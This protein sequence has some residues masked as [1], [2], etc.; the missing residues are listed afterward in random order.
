MGQTEEKL[1]GLLH[2]LGAEYDRMFPGDPDELLDQLKV[3]QAAGSRTPRAPQSR[4]WIASAALFVL[5]AV[6]GTLVEQ[7]QAYRAAERYKAPVPPQFWQDVQ[8]LYLPTTYT[9]I[10]PR[11]A[12]QRSCQIPVGHR[13]PGAPR[14]LQ[15]TCSTRVVSRSEYLALLPPSGGVFRSNSGELPM[16]AVILTES[17]P[18]P[19]FQTNVAVRRVSRLS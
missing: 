7:H 12:G 9:G 18:G 8:R 10:F 15:G 17:W 4:W 5:F 13:A 6:G 1:E 19:W 14:F 16:Q 11:S 2:K 3:N